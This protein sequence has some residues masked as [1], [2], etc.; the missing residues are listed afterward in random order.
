M[1]VTWTASQASVGEL[2]YLVVRGDDHAPAVPAD[3]TAVAAPTMNTKITDTGAPSGADL[4][5]SV[6]AALRR[7]CL[8]GGHHH[9]GHEVHPGR[10]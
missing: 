3:G 10:C 7:R 5:Y 2:H 9:T 8:V 4:F 1:L 6:F